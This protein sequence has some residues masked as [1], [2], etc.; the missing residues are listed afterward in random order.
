MSDEQATFQARGDFRRNR[1][2]LTTQE[3]EVVDISAGGMRLALDG[4]PPFA[5]GD[6][7][8]FTLAD[9]GPGFRLRGRIAWIRMPKG[10]G[11]LRGKRPE[12][13][14]EFIDMSEPDNRLLD[15]IAKGASVPEREEA[16][17]PQ[18]VRIEPTN[19]Y[20]IL[21]LE[22]D[23]EIDEIH[24]SYRRLAKETHPDLT[25]DPNAGERF[26][27][28]SKAY[29]VLRDNESRKAYDAYRRQAG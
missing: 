17:E 26:T 6:V 19:L 15:A 18:H 1:E 12:C 16:P 3:G 8:E 9:G 13:G 2:G 10:I 23:C 20:E 4:K 7:M 21:E 27:M 22:D 28:I 24:E 29:R 25:D 5:A 11:K 14:V